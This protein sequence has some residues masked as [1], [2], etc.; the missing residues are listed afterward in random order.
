M[1]KLKEILFE[2]TMTE[3][4]NYLRAMEH[5]DERP[6]IMLRFQNR[7]QSAFEIV[8]NAGLEAEYEAWL[9]ARGAEI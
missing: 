7:F 8:M 2:H 5:E 4:D 9:T 3:R 6:D 1:E